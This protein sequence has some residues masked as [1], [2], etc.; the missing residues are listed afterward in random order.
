M[1]PSRLNVNN[2]L[3]W[4]SINEFYDAGKVCGRGES[5]FLFFIACYTYIERMK[6]EP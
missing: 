6:I 5:A 2:V 1:P 4:F 3:H